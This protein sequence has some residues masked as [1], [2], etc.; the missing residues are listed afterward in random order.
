MKYLII[1]LGNYG[2]VLVE[3][4]SALGH[5]VVGVDSN[6]LAVDRLKDYMAM[7]YIMDATDEQALASLPLKTIDIGI[8]AV[9]ENFGASVRLVALLKQHKI[10]HIYARAVDHIH[11]GVLEAFGIERILTPEQ[12]AARLLVQC[13]ELGVNVETFKI[14]EEYYIFKFNIPSVLEGKQLQHWDIEEKHQLRIVSIVRSHTIWNNL[15][16]SVLS[17]SVAQQYPEDMALEKGDQI[18]CYGK[19]TD[20]MRYWH[21]LTAE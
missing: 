9:G 11:Q 16:V 12:D 7:S 6:E 18:V 1:G 14:D 20:F 2:S 21:G 10:P 19:Y 3:E 13:L 5:E 4:L 8:V 17:H 15:D